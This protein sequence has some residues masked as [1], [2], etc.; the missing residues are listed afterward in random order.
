MILAHARDA[1][2]PVALVGRQGGQNEL[3]LDLEVTSSL[4]LEELQEVL[5]RIAQ[6]RLVCAPQPQGRIQRMLV[7]VRQR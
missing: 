2:R 7:V 4:V 5:D 6:C 3:L 1:G